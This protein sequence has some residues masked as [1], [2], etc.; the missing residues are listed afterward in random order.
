M[1]V[2]EQFK[3]RPHRRESHGRH[4]RAN[5][6]DGRTPRATRGISQR[7]D[8]PN[9][10]FYLDPPYVH[11]TRTAKKVYK[12]EMSDRD[13]RELLETI[14][15]VEG[16]VLLSGYATRYFATVPVSSFR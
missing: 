4:R 1:M 14:R 12:F 11:E 13:H 9:T 15:Q 3:L 7:Y 5:T 10:L 8:S 16:K 6:S 2:D